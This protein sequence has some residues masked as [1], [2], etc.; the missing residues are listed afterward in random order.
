M[1]LAYPVGGDLPSI[2][3]WAKRLIEDLNR[4]AGVEELPTATDDADANAK[5]IRV[6]GAYV[7]PTG[8]VRRRVA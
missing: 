1:K 2:L 6:G 7:T 5:N 3:A 4:H 8:E